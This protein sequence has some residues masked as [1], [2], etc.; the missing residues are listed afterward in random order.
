MDGQHVP[1]VFGEWLRRRRKALDM[2]QS[3]LA[4]RVGC[5]VG[6]LR[7]IESGERRPSK[8]LANLFASALEL[9]DDDRPSFVR[10]ARGELSPERLRPPSRE[11]R[12]EQP[13]Q[14]LTGAGIQPG[15]P[16]GSPKRRI[17]PQAT[18]LIGRDGELAA[19]ERLFLKQQCRLLTLTGIGGIGKTR[20]AVAFAAC[21]QEAFPG[22]TYYVPLTSVDS[23]EKIIPAVA[24]AFDFGFS[25]PGVPQEQLFNYIAGSVEKKAL[26][27]LD[28]LEHLLVQNAAPSAAPSAV[29][30]VSEI[31]QRCENLHLLV[32]SRERL[33]IRDEWTYELH[34]LSVPPTIH[35]GKLEEFDSV[36]LFV[37]SA[38][39]CKAN[40][41][42]TPEEQPAIIKICQLVDGVPLAIEL[43]AAW[44][45]ILSCHEIAQEIQAN[46]DFLTTTMRDVPERHRSIRATFDHSWT[47]LSD[48]E[49]LALCQISVFRGGFDRFAGEHVAGATLSMLASLSNKSLV[50]RSESGRYDLHEVIRQYAS[51]HLEHSPKRFETHLRHC[52]YYLRQLSEHEWLLK[53]NRQ[54]E[55]VRQLTD[56]IE[57]ILDAWAYAVRHRFFDLLHQAGRAFGWYFEVM[58]LYREGIDFL[59]PLVQVLKDSPPNQQTQQL[60]GLVLLHQAL[61]HFRKGEFEPA[62]ELYEESIAVLRP[63]GDESLLADALIY[64]SIVLQNT[65]SYSKAKTLL[66]EGLALARVCHNRWLEGLGIL[67]AGYIASQLGRHA[68]GYEIMLEGLAIWRVVG[69]PHAIAMGLNFSI[70]TLLKLQRFAEAESFLQESIRLCEQSR[71][72]WGLGTAYSFLGAVYLAEGRYAAAKE[73][74]RKSLAIFTEQTVGWNVARSLSYLGDASRLSG[75]TEEANKYYLDG[76]TPSL[77]GKALPV[78]MD[79]LLGLS[80][81][82]DQAGRLERAY[83]LSSYV[84]QHPCSE[85][86]TKN[87]AGRLRSDLETRLQADQISRARAQA[88]TSMS[89]NVETVV[90]R[91]VQEAAL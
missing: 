72:R 27:I 54:Q 62:I 33:N 45:S 20:L 19:L 49:R 17:P 7:K 11:Q 81:L 55:S 68:E 24:N 26:L 9:S 13:I 40:F 89:A 44:V 53:S 47:L 14:W 30:L 87:R 4:L 57:N 77:Q 10:V 46:M 65:G 6:M 23:V 1:I 86:E 56:E 25:G 15:F 84:A 21:A 2:T 18:T 51:T 82:Q 35:A 67:N 32:I 43:A 52:E 8:Q 39:K 78:T 16:A 58:G 66:E 83:E 3:E 63:T 70:P 31:L 91:L 64:L 42:I 12:V 69:D 73:S 50:R 61:L 5:S 28:N 59:A 36:A 75:E 48:E 60:L 41:Q 22:G 29:E 34:G 80:Y 74:L 37:E 88:Q 79:I 76:L 71:N 85:Q 90:A 38:Q